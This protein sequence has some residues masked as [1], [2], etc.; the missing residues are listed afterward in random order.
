M[1]SYRHVVF[2]YKALQNIKKETK[3]GVL[4]IEL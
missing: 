4:I 1:D 3:N 2:Y